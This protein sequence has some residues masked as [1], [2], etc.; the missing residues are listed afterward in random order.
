M[1]WKEQA[2]DRFSSKKDAQKWSNI[3]TTENPSVDLISFRQRRDFTVNYVRDHCATGSTILDLGCGAGPVLTQLCQNEYNLI[4]IDY[5]NDMLHLAQQQLGEN[6]A[7]VPL[8]QGECEAIPL[9]DDSVDCI[10]CL[11]VISYA[12]SITTALQEMSRVLCS[13]G[14]AI[15][16][17]R[18]AL[19][20]EFMDPAQWP[21]SIW[22]LIFKSRKVRKKDIGRSIPRKEV[23]EHVALTGLHLVGEKQL[24]FGTIRF[25]KKIISDGSL[26]IKVNRVLHRCLISLRLNRL[27]RAMSDVHIVVVKK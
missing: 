10:V 8:M 18:N 7:R 25:N 16:S 2:L 13:D 22:R 11:G 26:A 6:V 4:G 17:Y 15:I 21:K 27:Y 9:P 23:L 19:N 14:I 24:G 12:E 5:S 20:D 3:Y 1:Q